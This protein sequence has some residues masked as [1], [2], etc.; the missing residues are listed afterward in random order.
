[1]I[2]YKQNDAYGTMSGRDNTE[3]APT[4]DNWTETWLKFLIK[5]LYFHQPLYFTKHNH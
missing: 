5:M 1:M 4:Y 2:S 3:A